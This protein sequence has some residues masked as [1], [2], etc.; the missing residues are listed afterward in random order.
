[1]TEIE[2][3]SAEVKVLSTILK[4]LYDNRDAPE[5]TLRRLVET[6][7]APKPG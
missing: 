4:I 5:A 1:M 7:Y 3:L 2:I 6:A